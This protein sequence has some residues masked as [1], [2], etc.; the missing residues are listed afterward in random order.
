M[1]ALLFLNQVKGMLLI[2]Q[3]SYT[4]TPLDNL[5]CSYAADHASGTLFVLG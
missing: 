1:L 2:I 4:E 5:I 3:D